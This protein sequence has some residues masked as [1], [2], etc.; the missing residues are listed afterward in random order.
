MLNSKKIFHLH[1][2]KT[3]GTAIREYLIAQVGASQITPLLGGVRLSDALLQWEHKQ[4]LSGHVVFHQGDDLPHDFYALTVLRDPVD[5][6]LSDLFYGKHQSPDQPRDA[7]LRLADL[8]SYI[9]AIEHKRQDAVALQLSMLY[10]IGAKESDSNLDISQKLAAAKSALDKFDLIGIQEDLDDTACML[11]AAMGWSQ[12]PL[13]RANQTWKRASVK[14]LSTTQRRQVESILAPEIELYEYARRR[15][16]QDRRRYIA[17]ASYRTTTEARIDS[18]QV[19]PGTYIE[20]SYSPRQSREPRNFG[21]KRCEV[22]RVGVKGGI[23]GAPEMLCGEHLL[24]EI[25]MAVHEPVENVTIGI[26]IRDERNALLFGT[27]SRLLGDAIELEPGRYL[28]SFSM[29]NRFGRGQYSI[30]ASL[31]K[32][33]SHHDGC[34]HWLENAA[35]FEV[36]DMATDYFEGRFMLDSD[37]DLA[38]TEGSPEPRRSSSHSDGTIVRSFGRM[39]PPLTDFSA[40]IQLLS[41]AHVLPAAT[42]SILQLRIRNTGQED[43]RACGY[44]G[45]ISPTYRWYSPTS[46]LL[47]PDGLRS[48]LPDDV[49]GGQTVIAPL[50]VRAPDEPG[51][52]R[53]AVS[54]VQEGVAWFIEE[55]ATSGFCID[56]EVV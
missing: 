2:P 9:D 24:I 8:D 13:E 55:N 46:E 48:I 3:G 38:A 6:F 34:Y 25:E 21:D 22:M 50:L 27:N 42:D 47:V 14:D 41:S 5:R 51:I 36:Y 10:P 45:R 7:R 16:Q 1:I 20:H 37:F 12:K 54:L 17:L 30:D 49:Q 53:L 32:D 44:Y 39:N 4:I 11:A 26:G 18:D 40:S 23:T 35:R 19:V 28:A 29:L 31:I 43:W 56:I 33:L 52:Y 15:F